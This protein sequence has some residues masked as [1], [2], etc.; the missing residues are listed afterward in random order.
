MLLLLAFGRV[1]RSRIPTLLKTVRAHVY[2]RSRSFS[3]HPE[4]ETIEQVRGADSPGN[5]V[6]HFN[7]Q[8]SFHHSGSYSTN[9]SISRSLLSS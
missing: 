8:L 4:L 6:L 2:Q 3:H 9:L 7:V 5:R 1:C